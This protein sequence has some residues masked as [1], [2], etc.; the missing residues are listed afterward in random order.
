M[1]NAKQMFE[2][3]GFK[4][5]TIIGDEEFIKNHI[6]YEKEI[7]IDGMF[8]ACKLIV[9]FSKENKTVSVF[10]DDIEKDH[11]EYYSEPV[12]MDLELIKAIHQQ[13][14]ELK[15]SKKFKGTKNG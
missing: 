5:G 7:L 9:F 11:E 3:I 13:L 8:Y 2:K 12:E 15:E 14:K 4:I 1:M 10:Y 6:K